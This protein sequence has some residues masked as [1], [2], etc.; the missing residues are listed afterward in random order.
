MQLRNKHHRKSIAQASQKIRCISVANVR[1]GKLKLPA[2]PDKLLLQRDQH[3]RQHDLRMWMPDLSDGWLKTTKG[4]PSIWP[5]P[6]LWQKPRLLPWTRKG[7]P[8]AIADICVASICNQN[9]YSN[10]KAGLLE[11]PSFPSIQITNKSHIL[12]IRPMKIIRTW[13]DRPHFDLITELTR[14]GGSSKAKTKRQ[15]Q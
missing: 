4:M 11:S 1:S 12:E 6:I 13:W 8:R 3:F 7:M 5:W 15:K 10:E 14:H 2:P 9:R